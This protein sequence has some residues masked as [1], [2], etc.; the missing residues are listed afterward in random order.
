M[1]TE[2]A[3]FSHN[4]EKIA[5][6]TDSCAD[7]S[8]KLRKNKPVFVVPLHVRCTDGEFLDG[9]DIFAQD[10][11]RRQQLGEMPS[12]SLPS[13]GRV[14]AVLDEIAA[15][16]KLPPSQFMPILSDLE[17]QEYIRSA[18]GGKYLKV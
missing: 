6:L 16:L 13:G 15:A 11:Y 4:P 18:E 1:S 10:I 5:F 2:A 8:P 12:T 14:S 3:R 9:E 7:L 17:I